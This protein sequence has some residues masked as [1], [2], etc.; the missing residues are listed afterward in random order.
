M[1]VSKN[2]LNKSLKK[3]VINTFLQ[4]LDDLKNKSE[5]ETFLTD[6]FNQNELETYS[7]RLAIIYW[8]SK[9]RSYQNIKT[10]LKVSSATVAT[11]EKLMNKKGIELAITKMAA[12]EWANVWSEK[13][14]RLGT[15]T[16]N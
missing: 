15:R 5:K 9:K 10:N 16:R 14:K 3:E 1:R 8:L 12:E 11:V 4:T 13:I 2:E 6:F 7:K